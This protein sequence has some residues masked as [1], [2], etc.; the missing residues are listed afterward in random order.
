MPKIA[1]ESLPNGLIDA[2]RERRAILFLGSGASLGSTSPSGKKMPTAKQLAEAIADEFLN[3]KFR[4]KDL[5]RVAEIAHSQAGSSRFNQW[6]REFFEVFEPTEAHKALANFR[7]RAIVTTNYDLLV[8]NGY[9]ANQGR[10]QEIVKRVKDDEPI[11]SMLS[12]F[13]HPVEYVK[14]HGC[15]EH[16]HDK[17]I[18]LVLTPESYNDHEANR[19]DLYNRLEGLANEYTIIFCGHSLN[20]LHIRRL[21]ENPRRRTRPMYYL[22]SPDFE[23][24]ERQMWSDKRVEA[25]SGTFT[26]FMQALNIALPPLMRVPVVAEMVVQEPYRKHF[27]VSERE[28]DETAYAFKNEIR[29]LSAGMKITDVDPKKFYAGFDQSWGNIARDFDIQRRVSSQILEYIGSGKDEMTQ[30]AVIHGPAGYGKS[31]AL[32]RAAW[33]LSVSFGEFVVWLDDDS[34]LRPDVLKEIFNLSG[35]RIY[36]FI[37]RSGLNCLKI[38]EILALSRAERI[39]VTIVSAERR[40]EWSIYCQKLEK[41]QPQ[42]FEINKLSEAEISDLL[43][44]L[45]IHGCEGILSG[46]TEDKKRQMIVERL[47]RQL[48]VAL[49]EI[50]RGRSF[51]EI[52]VDEYSR[53]PGEDAQK[54]YL[55]VCTLDRFDVPARAGVISRISGI[56]FRDF[57]SELFVPLQDLV[58]TKQNSITSDW[59]YRTR[60]PIVA[61]IIFNSVC[62]TDEDRRDQI[63]RLIYGLDTSY[64]SDELALS[65][66]MR[67]RSLAE[68]FEDASLVRQIYD[69]AVQRNPARPFISQQ[70]AVF[71]YT[72]LKGQLDEADAAI[73]T[74]LNKEPKNPSFLHTQAQ[75]YR[76][77]AL[78]TKSDFARSSFRAKSRAALD[79]IPD[80]TNAYVLGTRARLR[81]DSVGD[82]LA[83]LRASA[84]DVHE[85]ELAEAIDQAEIALHRAFNM[86]PADPDFLEAEAKLKELLGDTAASTDRLQ[87]AWQRM[88]RGSG[89]AKRL[90][91]RY[92]SVGKTDSAIKVLMEAAERDPT[93]RSVNL[94]LSCIHFE[95]S[96]IDDVSA[97]RFLAK[98]FVSGDR[99]YHARFVAAAVLFAQRQ[100]EK[101]YG[102]IDEIDKGAPHDFYPNLGWMER[103]L[104]PHFSSYSGVL[105]SS[106]GSY[107]FIRMED[108]PRHI[109]APVSKSADEKWD[110]LRIN[111]R[112]NFDVEFARKGPVG[113]NVRKV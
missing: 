91:R 108:C 83:R 97:Q 23:D 102:L 15:I 52:V 69:V 73:S 85:D 76:R 93:D 2:M 18:P 71:E 45:R 105:S 27:R 66:L 44:K 51:Q 32:M 82:A 81:V 109:F 33:E 31:I 17:D 57:E 75:V 110:V 68:T 101:S 49:Y 30:L 79:K 77:R 94:L 95:Q 112:V 78:E 96:G 11:E 60:H 4:N 13:Q 22:V 8:E 92:L 12:R 53:L 36:V 87:R 62:R 39:P 58:F 59:E 42:F 24:E 14:L 104:I 26:S 67:G 37:D 74:A 64:R 3:P 72:H 80:Q 25:I 111:D 6:I 34:K 16:V 84:S 10:L 99:E 113:V 106:F 48:L 43:E 47:D 29:F 21:V 56:A 86:Y 46:E 88:P 90:S 35:K 55:D 63:I 100:F 40:N 41:Y 98:S 7:W 107:V 54:L 19:Q 5:M 103:W 61:E 65:Q 9:R 20:D 1:Q 89:I 28:S 50:T 70:R 38:E